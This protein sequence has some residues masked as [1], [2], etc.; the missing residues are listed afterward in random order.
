[1]AERIPSNPDFL[2]G[3]EIDPEGNLT[4]DPS[5]HSYKIA[6]DYIG[7]S[8]YTWKGMMTLKFYGSHYSNASISA[9]Y[10]RKKFL[11]YFMNDLRSKLRI[12]EREFGWVACTEYGV[13]DVPHYH[14]IFTFDRLYSKGRSDK[15][16]DWNF[17]K[18]NRF[19]IEANESKRKSCEEY[20]LKETGVKIDWSPQWDNCGLVRYFCKIEFGRTSDKFE[21][22]AFFWNGEKRRNAAA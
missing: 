21:Y 5:K 17:G 6:K 4:F 9:A 15:V 14:I 19:S 20:E 12:S 11:Y 16:P 13:K 22:P 18:H 3:V 10:S 7:L 1:M 2:P 8:E